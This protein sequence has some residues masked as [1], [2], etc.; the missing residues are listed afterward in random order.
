MPWCDVRIMPDADLKAMYVYIRS[1]GPGGEAAPS[2][3]PPGT[4][5]A[6]PVVQFPG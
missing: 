6:G 3:V 2:Y 5:P 4:K 1:L